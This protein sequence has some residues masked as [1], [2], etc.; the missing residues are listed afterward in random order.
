ML[1]DDSIF[2]SADTFIFWLQFTKAKTKLSLSHLPKGTLRASY[3]LIW[4]ISTKPCGEI[5]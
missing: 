2:V 3:A 5:L 1:G 4:L